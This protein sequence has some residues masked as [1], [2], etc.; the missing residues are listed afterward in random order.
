MM[1]ASVREPPS[2]TLARQDID[3]DALVLIRA[4]RKDVS[5]S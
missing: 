5:G 3:L 4:S 1:L 2:L